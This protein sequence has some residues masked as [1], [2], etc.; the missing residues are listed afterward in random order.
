[1]IDDNNLLISA[2]RDALELGEL[3]QE[4]IDYYNGQIATLEEANRQHNLKITS[5]VTLITNTDI[6]M[7]DITSR[8][9]EIQTRLNQLEAILANV[10]DGGSGVGDLISRYQAERAMLEAQLAGLGGSTVSVIQVNEEITAKSSNIYVAADSLTGQGNLLAPGDTLIRVENKSPKFLRTNKMMIP[11]EAGGQI[12][13]NSVSVIDNTE[14]NQR[15]FGT[16]AQFGQI[17]TADNT[18]PRIIV[19]NSYI[20]YSG[21]RAPD[22]FVDADIRTRNGLAHI[23]SAYGSVQIKDGVDVVADTIKISAGRDIFIGYKDGFRNLGGDIRAHWANVIASS[24]VQGA[25]R[26]DSRTP[27]AI[28]GI[29]GPYDPSILAGNNVFISGQY[30]NI[31]GVVQSGLPERILEIPASLATEIA[32][33]KRKYNAGDVTDSIYKG[34][35]INTGIADDPSRIPVFYNAELDYLELAPVETMGGYME[36]YGHIMNTSVGELRV[37]DGYGT[38]D[39]SNYTGTP[40]RLSTLNTGSGIEGTIKIT[41]TAKHITVGTMSVPLVT[42]Y[43]R[44]GNDIKVFTNNNATGQVDLNSPVSTTIGRSTLY[45]PLDHQYYSWTVRDRATWREWAYKYKETWFFIF[46]DDEV[47]F[48]WGGVESYNR[49]AQTPIGAAVVRQVLNHNQTYWY[50]RSYYLNIG[51]WAS[52]GGWET[53]KNVIEV[54]KKE[55]QRHERS[56]TETIIH[57]HNV[58]ASNPI[59]INFLG[60]DTG[61]LTVNSVGNI[62]IDGQLK[63]TVGNTL[64]QTQGAIEQGTSEWAGIIAD[65]LTLTAGTGIGTSNRSVLTD[66]V[67][68]GSVTAST[69]AGDIYLE[70]TKGSLTFDS[71]T[72]TSGK[73]NLTAESGMVGKSATSLVKGNGVNLQV[74]HGG[75]GTA[76]SAVRV[77]TQAEQ[78]GGLSATAASDIYLTETNGDLYLGQV[79][80]TG[81]NVSVAAQAG[82]II[83]NNAAQT[84]DTRVKAELLQLW[85]EMALTGEKAAES[86]EHTVA[87]YE[88]T[89]EHEYQTYWQYRQRFV[90]EDGSVLP[91]T[92]DST[93]TL[94]DT[95]AAY[96][97]TELG[98]SETEIAALES[99]MT[100]D[101]HGFYQAYGELSVAYDP[102]W[103]YTA[104]ASEREALVA[105]AAWTE[106]QLENSFGLGILKEVSDTRIWIEDPNV[107][108]RDIELW[109]AQAIGQDMTTEPFTIKLDGR[110]WSELTAEEKLM[111]LSAERKDITFVSANEIRITPTQAVDIQVSG[112]VTATAT[113]SIYLGSESDLNLDHII[114]GADV[115]IKTRQNIINA[116]DPGVINII[117]QDTILEAGRGSIGQDGDAVV[118]DLGNGTLTARAAGDLYLESTDDDLYIDT[119]YA[120]DH[121]NLV[122]PKSIVNVGNSDLNIRAESLDLQARTGSIGDSLR[123]LQIG[124]NPTGSLVASAAGD[125]YLN[126]PRH[127]LRTDKVT[128][129][130]NITIFGGD[131]IIVLSAKGGVGTALGDVR[132]DAAGSITDGDDDENSA[133][134]GQNIHLLVG[135][136]IGSTDNDLQIDTL[137]QGRIKITANDG[138]FL[139]EVAGDIDA[140][141]ITSTTGSVRLTVLTGD[142]QA[143][144][145]SAGGDLDLIAQGAIQAGQITSGGDTTLTAQ[146]GDIDL[147]KFTARGAVSA[148]AAGNI[149]L[150]EVNGELNVGRMVA[151]AGDIGITAE[152]SIFDTSS[153]D[154]VNFQGTNITLTSEA[155]RIGANSARIVTAG[156]GI[157]NI[158]AKGDVYLEERYDDLVSDYVTSEAGS[159]D[160]LVPDGSIRIQRLRAADLVTLL[161]P[162]GIE[163][164]QIEAGRLSLSLTG[165]GSLL[166]INDAYIA[167]ELTAYADKIRLAN[168]VH[169][170]VDPLNLSLGGG[171]KG[172]ADS[173]EVQTT[174]DVGVV[175]NHISGDHIRFNGQVDQLDFLNALVGTRAD[176]NSKYHTVIA[177]NVQKKLFECNLQILPKDNQF[178]LSMGVDRDL[179]TD[180][181]VVNYDPYYIINDF[182][183]ENSFI[184]MTSKMLEVV[185][186]P[187]SAVSQQ[188]SVVN[189]QESTVGKSE[190]N[191]IPNIVVNKTSTNLVDE[192]ADEEEVVN[193]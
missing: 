68:S 54:Y 10:D 5:N 161:T 91:Y 110:T 72:A 31:N 191:L 118:V 57:N 147:D 99:K 145:V 51:D 76:T 155:G 172:M 35:S 25:D 171:S 66:L 7:Q 56:V 158:L 166:S 187:A 88:R 2:C 180:A 146:S 17:L 105:G 139:T 27:E 24:E 175:V 49:S 174:S 189:Q 47:E 126:S 123:M 52:K 61:S 152:G 20:P 150:A 45:N 190:T 141:E 100:A 164:G 34:L 122:S 103:S 179:R 119:I 22:I 86:A 36:L 26:S 55:R 28:L 192:K 97:C 102:N 101:Y 12:Y 129:N 77:D 1:M 85:D 130:G 50:D 41:D 184:R 176:I 62:V 46:S 137:S 104:T 79:E 43:K 127:S 4:Q 92:P 78:E 30:L 73:V 162:Y 69:A 82:S 16:R 11:D 8:L 163:L 112:K 98:W 38:I 148:T 125:I 142:L 6:V 181:K 173:I 19:V 120:V 170:G 188:A 143:D 64:I 83:D 58:Y 128:A 156:S 42:V 95:E 63:N 75:I 149:W 159:V 65:Q 193:D 3:T 90:A 80:S 23:T 14:I 39:I 185:N 114:A 87:A 113:G 178:Y 144:V 89:K 117:G 15:N 140:E 18:I 186:R 94:T 93:I 9:T 115:R 48:S 33:Y 13:F 124:I 60:E 134:T 151:I 81:G 29:N 167:K 138:I 121:V 67:D 53:V 135:G 177:D 182:N 183:T 133:I 107:A 165:E 108:G 111:I 116:A 37:M 21:E 132:L 154:L 106:Q 84:E 40:L 157:T 59:K 44:L 136:A 153:S 70:E 109:A 74:R 32:E 71:I 131:N 169:T 96:Y 160:L 168:L